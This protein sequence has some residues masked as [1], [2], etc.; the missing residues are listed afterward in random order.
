MENLL[1]LP[2]RRKSMFAR[3]LPNFVGLPLYYPDNI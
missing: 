2:G 3:A 1:W